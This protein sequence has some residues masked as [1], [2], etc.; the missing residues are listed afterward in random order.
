MKSKKRKIFNWIK[1]I[2]FLYCSIGIALYYLQEKFLF[3]P[4]PLPASHVFHF[5]GKFNEMTIPIN[6]KDNISMVRFLPD[7]G[8]SRGVVL[9]FHGN[10]GNVERYARAQ[11]TV[12]KKHFMNRRTRFTDW[13]NRS[14]EW[15]VSLSMENL[16]EQELPHSLLQKLNP[17]Y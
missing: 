10:R 6:A 7:S 4:T 15:I 1:I 8:A 12:Q 13:Q 5:P 2:V 11:A 3:H 9:F 17:D 14:L 16:S